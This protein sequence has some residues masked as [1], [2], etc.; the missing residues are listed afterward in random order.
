MTQEVPAKGRS[1]PISPH[2]A[3]AAK[4]VLAGH[5]ALRDSGDERTESQVFSHSVDR[6]DQLPADALAPET[7]I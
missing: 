1:P 6:F 3:R 4:T 2:I 5:I 7:G